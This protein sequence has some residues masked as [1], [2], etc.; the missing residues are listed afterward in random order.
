MTCSIPLVLTRRTLH[1]TTLDWAENLLEAL[2]RSGRS[3][4]DLLVAFR[5]VTGFVMGFV[6]AQLAQ[7]VMGGHG[8]PD[9]ARAQALP[10]DRYPRLI[11]IAKEASRL[12]PDREFRTG[13]EIVMSGLTA[14]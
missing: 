4:T 7:P 6:Q 10:P 12:G 2:S 8:H 3:G 5:T 14:S 13:L 1:D 9:I 11:E